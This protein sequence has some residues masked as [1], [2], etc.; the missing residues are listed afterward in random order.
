MPRIFVTATLTAILISILT[1]LPASAQINEKRY[2]NLRK[3]QCEDT[4]TRADMAEIWKSMQDDSGRSATSVIGTV[5]VVSS[6][7][8]RKTPS[9]LVC[10]VVIEAVNRGSKRR[11][12][13]IFAL[14]VFPQGNWNVK[15]T[16]G[17]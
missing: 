10:Q 1:A 3:V 9:K 8:L 7:T 5:N 14:N 4:Q 2:A 17:Y 15:F 12:R 13:G 6:R 16:S 11:I